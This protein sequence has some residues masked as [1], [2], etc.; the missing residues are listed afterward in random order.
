MTKTRRFVEVPSRPSSILSSISSSYRF[1]SI[2]Y[3]LV[4]LYHVRPG[5]NTNNTNGS[6]RGA[7]SS[8]DRDRRRS[9]G[10]TLRHPAH[11]AQAERRAARWS[12][13]VN[14]VRSYERTSISVPGNTVVDQDV[15]RPKGKRSRGG[16]NF[17]KFAETVEEGAWDDEQ[18]KRDLEVRQT[19]TARRSPLTICACLC[20]TA[21]PPSPASRA[22]KASGAPRSRGDC[23]PRSPRP[24]RWARPPRRRPPRR[25]PPRN[26]RA[27]TRRRA[28]TRSSSAR[29]R[30]R[31]RRFGGACPRPRASLCFVVVDLAD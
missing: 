11:Q 15:A 24:P 7:S 12:T 30:R 16:L 19:H 14:L 9:A 2:T 4:C 20:R 8:Y 28:S 23:P 29:C 27:R 21:W 13:C 26:A 6:A 25:R 18:A 3:V 5:C 1:P 17:F 10:T 31:T 22:R